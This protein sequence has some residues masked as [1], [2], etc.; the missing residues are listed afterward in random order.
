MGAM[1]T[2]SQTATPRLRYHQNAYKFVFQALRYTQEHLRRN[3]SGGPDDEEAHIS[4]QELLAGIRAL[5]LEQ[6]GL[7]AT[8][9]FRQ[10]GVT[11]TNDFGHIV[12]ELIERGE[13]RKTD[14]D[15]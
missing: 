15:Q 13:M 6:F 9:V 1:T 10:W 12:W 2:T 11:T 4:G 5:A 14:R 3:V 7:L 8:T